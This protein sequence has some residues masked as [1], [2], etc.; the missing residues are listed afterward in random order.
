M[1][2]LVQWA[3][4]KQAADHVGI[5]AELIGQAVRDGEIPS[6]A[7]GK[8]MVSYRLDLREVDEWMKS[9]ARVTA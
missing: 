4:K 3:T 8:G 6:Y 9:R 2:E 7:V 1:A 5:S